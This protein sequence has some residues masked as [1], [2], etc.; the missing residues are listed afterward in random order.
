[1]NMPPMNRSAMTMNTVGNDGYQVNQSMQQMATR[2][3]AMAE[4]QG[5][6]MVAQNDRAMDELQNAAAQQTSAASDFANARI[7][8]LKNATTGNQGAEALQQID[9]QALQ[10]LVESL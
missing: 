4:A 7:A 5:A 9:P 2:D 8:A 10:A 1:M 6:Q 3:Q